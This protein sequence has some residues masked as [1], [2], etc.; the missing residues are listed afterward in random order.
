MAYVG[1]DR[2]NKTLGLLKLIKE[3][4]R[5]RLINFLIRKPKCGDSGPKLHGF[6]TVI[7]ILDF[8]IA[9]PLNAVDGTI[10]PSCMMLMEDGAQARIKLMPPL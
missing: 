8:S 3:L 5:M 7:V 4:W 1:Y 10:L 6:V 2:N 9:K